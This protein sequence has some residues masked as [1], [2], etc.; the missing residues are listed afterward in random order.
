MDYEISREDV[1]QTKKEALSYFDNGKMDLSVKVI[2]PQI[3]V[4]LAW[5][6]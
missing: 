2:I 5:K 3:E 4:E 1:Y 6:T